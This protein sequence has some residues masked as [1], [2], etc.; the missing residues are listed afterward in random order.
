MASTLRP[1]PGGSHVC[2]MFKQHAH[3]H[4]YCRSRMYYVSDVRGT[5]KE[6]VEALPKGRQSKQDQGGNVHT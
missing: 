6:A 1:Q 3:T 4:I 2:R 5:G